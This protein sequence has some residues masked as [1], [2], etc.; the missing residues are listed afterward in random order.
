MKYKMRILLPAFVLLITN[1]VQA[2][3]KLQLC[4]SYDVN[5][6][7]ENT[8][9]SWKISKTGN[10]MYILY[11]SD[12]PIED[13][14]YITLSKTYSRK[15]TSY[16]QYDH[17]YLIPDA[18]K[19]FAANK[20]IFSKPGNYIISVFDKHTEELLQSYTTVIDFADD[21]Y[22][23]PY[24]T[25][26]WYYKLSQMYFGDTMV[27]EKLIGKSEV[28]TYKPGGNKITLYISQQNHS[29]LKSQHLIVKIISKETNKL[30][31]TNSYNI[32]TDWYWTYL[33]VYIDNK[34]KYTVE[35]Y[36][37]DDVFINKA[38]LEIK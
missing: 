28:F 14:L 16:Y 4:T 30:I 22:R 19:K 11:Q 35:M 38:D 13:S 29:P 15:D 37:E 1:M 21:D 12:T 34:G 26:T 9:P 17:Y 3:N 31:K 33:P 23:D 7:P 6:T 32:F 27:G 10:F 8:Y 24:F 25:D 18:S 5:G 20:Y 36:N 2:E